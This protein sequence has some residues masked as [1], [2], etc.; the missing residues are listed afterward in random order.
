MKLTTARYARMLTNTRNV[1][2]YLRNVAKVIREISKHLIQLS[3]HSGPF[4]NNM[5]FMVVK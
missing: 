4:N 2:I 5:K 3:I 1:V